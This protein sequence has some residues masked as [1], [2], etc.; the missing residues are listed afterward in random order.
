[1]E[2]PV[3]GNRVIV[4]RSAILA[5]GLAFTSAFF[6]AQQS[7]ASYG[8]AS[9]ATAP[10]LRVDAKGTAEVTWTEGG[11]RISF[12]VP[13]TGVG[14]HAKLSSSNVF[15]RARVAVPMAVVTGKTPD[16]TLWALQQRRVSG[17]STSLDLSRWR[18]APTRITLATDGA[19][20][21]GRATFGGRPVTGSSPTLTGK[22]VRAYVFLECFGCPAKRNGWTFMLGVAP[23]ADGTFTAFLQAGWTGERYRAT[24]QGPNVRGQ[25]APDARIVI[26][27]VRS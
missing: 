6:Y 25:L 4:K 7:A 27:A 10:A 19:R 2:M 3:T 21:T 14:Y 15:R 20:L 17:Q 13:K 12:L 18:G 9:G 1:M 26:D 24:L 5:L 16:G 22:R 8:I 11:R 23:R